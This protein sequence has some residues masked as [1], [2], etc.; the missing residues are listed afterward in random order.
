[1]CT[2]LTM[3]RVIVWCQSDTKPLCETKLN[4]LDGGIY[5]ALLCHIC[6]PMDQSP[7]L[8]RMNQ[9][10]EEKF[11]WYMFIELV[12]SL[13]CFKSAFIYYIKAAVRMRIIS[14]IYEYIY[15][16]RVEWWWKKIEILTCITAPHRCFPSIPMHVYDIQVKYYLSDTD[17]TVNKVYLILSY[18][19]KDTDVA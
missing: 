16:N 14:K 7:S 6:R 3:D 8:V 11:W 19:S 4:G 12:T 9:F 18:I 2:N 13:S 17:Q 10:T 15:W 5:M 1:M